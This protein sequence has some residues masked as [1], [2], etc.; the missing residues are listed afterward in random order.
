MISVTT[1]V[2]A[3]AWT[4]RSAGAY[5]VLSK[6]TMA[7]SNGTADRAWWAQYF[8]TVDPMST[9]D[10]CLHR[11]LGLSLPD[12]I[13]IHFPTSFKTG[14]VVDGRSLADV[15]AGQRALHGDLSRYDAL[16]EQATAYYV[17]DLAS[18]V[19][20]F[21]R[22]GVPSLRRT[23]ALGDG[24]PMW[25]ATVASPASALV[26]EVHAP[27]CS[28]AA[29][30]H[31]FAPHG[32]DECGAAHALRRPVAWYETQWAA[33]V[34]LD[35]G[36]DR[37]ASDV[38]KPVLAQVRSAVEDG[39]AAAAFV[40]AH[41]ADDVVASAHSDGRAC[42]WTEFAVR[43]APFMTRRR[44]MT[45]HSV[46]VVFVRN[47][48]AEGTAVRDWRD[49]ARALHAAYV[50][51]GWGFDRL[52]DNHL[53]FTQH[54]RE[55]T[56]YGASLD[57]HARRLDDDGGRFHAFNVS[58]NCPSVHTP[59]F[60]AGFMLYADGVDALTG[61]E[62]WGETVDGSYFGDRALFGWNG[63]SPSMGCTADAPP[64]MCHTT[65][66]RTL[67]PADPP[68]DLAR[69]VLGCAGEGATIAG[70]PFASYGAPTGDCASGFARTAACDAPGAAA[71]VA[72]ACV[73][74]RA[75]TV[76]LAAFANVTCAGHDLLWLATEVDCE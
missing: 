17:P 15:Q 74:K 2:V 60:D 18:H 24:T 26:F 4:L 6:R 58:R 63:C 48:N 14:S 33:A 66:G 21:T 7:S 20:A 9:E 40:K 49:W 47:G 56:K 38:L 39:G 11:E 8:G 36:G 51:T 71:A 72:A 19:A 75:C 37:L 30:C 10:A 22:D 35:G 1:L 45:N 46:D 41:L 29:F 61:V 42:A 52:L 62:L 32:A 54:D 69:A 27:A 55:T 43:T 5:T 16:L 76:D 70:V 34:A 3:C 25:A 57:A 67:V 50:G 65:H 23:Y 68:T 31:S 53:K 13:G 28:N 59:V 12:G 64:R 73:G 44:K